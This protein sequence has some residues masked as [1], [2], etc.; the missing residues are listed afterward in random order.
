[1]NKIFYSTILAGAAALASTSAS[2]ATTLTFSNACGGL[3]TDGSAISQSYGDLSGI[4]DISYRSVTG[5]GSDIGAG[6]AFVWNGGYA[7]LS[8]VAYGAKNGTLEIAFRLLDPTKKITFDS[9][10]YASWNSLGVTTQLGIYAL[11]SVASLTTGDLEASTVIAPNTTHAT[12]S[13]NFTSLDGF[14]FHF[15][16]DAY[17]AGIDNLT[18]T[19]SNVAVTAVPEPATWFSM[20]LGFGV[21]G[22][23][24]RRRTARRAVAIV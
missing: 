4:L 15:G 2:A 7:D 19:I 1:M 23:A 12:W 21:I 17:Y 22:V 5:Q 18:F 20:I 8:D 13:P 9:V 16:S 3:C 24:T 11:G 14:R 6:D 10:D